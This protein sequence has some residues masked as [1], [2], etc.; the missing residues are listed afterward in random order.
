LD[1]PEAGDRSIPIG[2]PEA[3]RMPE[4][5]GSVDGPIAVKAD[6]TTSQPWWIDW[7]NENTIY[8]MYQTSPQF[9][10]PPRFACETVLRNID[11]PAGQA[12]AIMFFP[13]PDQN[14]ILQI[15]YSIIPDAALRCSAIRLRRGQIPGVIHRELLGHGRAAIRQHDG[16]MTKKFNDM[17]LAAVS[18]DNKNR[19]AKIGYNANRE[20]QAWRGYRHTC[21][22]AFYYNDDPIT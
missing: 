16:V 18:E 2:R 14:Y 17:L 7:K 19:P 11:P 21:P 15:K 20:N 22:T 6:A 9:T 1:I 12:R 4:D 13:T 8:Q 5:F 3:I 10:G